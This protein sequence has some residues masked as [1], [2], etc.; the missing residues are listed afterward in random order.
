MTAEQFFFILAYRNHRAFRIL[1]SMLDNGKLPVAVKE[2][3]E[4][5]AGTL[6]DSSTKATATALG[7]ETAAVFDAL[8]TACDSSAL[9]EH[10]LY[11][12]VCRAFDWIK[13]VFDAL[14][15]TPGMITQGRP[16]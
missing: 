8:Q 1:A 9:Q 10:I 6:R 13:G 11:S 4:N 16:R 3:I 7:D 2:M 5:A 12:E 14:I 15:P